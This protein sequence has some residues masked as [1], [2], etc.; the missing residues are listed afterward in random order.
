MPAIPERDLSLPTSG[1]R[2]AYAR[3]LTSGKHPLVARVIVNRIWMHHFGQAIV[4]TPSEFG[5]LG[6][7]PSNPLL[8]DWLADEFMRGGWD[9]KQ[10]H[11]LIMMS[12]TWRQ[13]S[14]RDPAKSAVDAENAYYWRKTIQRLDAEVI[15]DRMLVASGTLEPNLFGPPVAIKADETGQV[16]VDGQQKRR[17]LY[18]QVRRSQPVAMLQSFDAPV[19]DVNCERRPVSTVATQSLI[20][21][22]G[23]YAWQQADLLA[24]RAMREAV[25][26]TASQIA[27]LPE[28]PK[29]EPPEWKFMDLATQLH[30]AWR[31]IY[32]RPPTSDEFRL[33]TMHAVTQLRA[34]QNDPRGIAPGSNIAKQVLVNYCHLLL[35]SNEFVYVD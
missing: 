16:I 30:F 24:A 19:M 6:M 5:K 26:L 28:P 31:L 2:L 7:V 22:N 13:S 1:R 10:L 18:L 9:L 17:S 12:T 25:P 20:L 11:R 32:C 8:L 3:S 33:S 4:P 14:V 35:N 27:I 23:E 15:R 34:I 21:M 29:P